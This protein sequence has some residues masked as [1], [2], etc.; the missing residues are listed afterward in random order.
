MVRMVCNIRVYKMGSTNFIRKQLK[1]RLTDKQS[2]RDLPNQITY[3]ELR[4]LDPPAVIWRPTSSE[5]ALLFRLRHFL[6]DNAKAD[7][8][9]TINTRAKKKILEFIL[10]LYLFIYYISF[11]LGIVYADVQLNFFSQTNILI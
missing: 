4:Q 2:L 3:H 10:S 11:F 8:I 7:R 6:A 9:L 1:E 5:I